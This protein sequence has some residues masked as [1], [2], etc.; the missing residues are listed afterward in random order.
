MILAAMGTNIKD[1]TATK[2]TKLFAE[3]LM[4]A[5]IGLVV[6]AVVSGLTFNLI[7]EIMYK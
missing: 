4:M 5:C 7:A 3:L 2:Q 6:I 1:F